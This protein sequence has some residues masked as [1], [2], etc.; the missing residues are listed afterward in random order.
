MDIDVIGATV[1][2]TSRAPRTAGCRPR[3]E[4]VASELPEL[5]AAF[6]T[7]DDLRRTTAPLR[8]RAAAADRLA[9]ARLAVRGC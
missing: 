5:L 9:R 7:H 6:T 2:D 8:D 1:I 4:V 3:A